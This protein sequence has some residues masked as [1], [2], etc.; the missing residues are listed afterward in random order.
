ME[1]QIAFTFDSGELAGKE[2]VTFEELYDTSNPENP[3]KVAEHK[4]IEDKGQTV[5]VKETPKIPTPKTPAKP[6]TPTST[7]NKTSNAPKTG[8]N[9]PLTMLLAMMGMSIAGI[10]FALYKKRSSM[11][12][13]DN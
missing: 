12:K 9:T 11:K 6:D 7:T 4:D 1:V 2:L 5:K 13:S 3:V 8:D 10:S